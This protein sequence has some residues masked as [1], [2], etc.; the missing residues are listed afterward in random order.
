V[1][2]VLL[3]TEAELG[4][5]V[6]GH[7][8]LEQVL[9]DSSAAG[10]PLAL[11]VLHV[12]NPNP[13]LRQLTRGIP[14]L[15]RVDGDLQQL[16]WHLVHSF[17]A[18]RAV[19]QRLAAAGPYDALL[20][21][22][23][24]VVFGLERWRPDDIP[25]VVSTD[26]ST[27]QWREFGLWRRS[28]AGTRLTL[29]IT[30]RLE[31][32]AMVAADQVLAWSAWTQAG[33]AFAGVSAVRWHPGI[34]RRWLREPQPIPPGP[35]LVLFVGGR[36]AE[37]GGQTFLDAVRPLLAARLIDAHIVTSEPKQV[38]AEPGLVVSSLEP[39][40]PRL[41]ALY[42]KAAV[43]VLPSRGE[44]V[45]WVVIEALTRGCAV[46]ATDVGAISEMIGGGGRVVAEAEVPQ[47]LATLVASPDR[48][49]DLQQAARTAGE[50]FDGVRAAEELVRHLETLTARRSGSL[51]R[52]AERAP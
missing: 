18:R 29:R 5:G 16:R 1:I 21:H 12:P 27:R 40:D 48:L 32:R 26:V 10:V 6:L 47:E 44:A 19:R 52:G 22:T 39:G 34:E 13:L 17:L 49:A 2:R 9:T 28:G 15:R 25:V 50:S 7:L 14:G 24:S 45:P 35:P 11:E 23:Q 42:D 51:P 33:L 3:V 46:L 43:L 4:T 30:E 37:K 41:L 31:G 38:P 20:L 36:F 8:R